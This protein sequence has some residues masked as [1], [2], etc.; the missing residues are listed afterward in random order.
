MRISAIIFITFDVHSTYTADT[1]SDHVLYSL[2][3]LFRFEPA[4]NVI[5]FW[6]KKFERVNL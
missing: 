4:D 6:L 1:L 2:D 3:D 5:F